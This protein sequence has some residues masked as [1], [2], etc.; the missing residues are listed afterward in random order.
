MTSGYKAPDVPAGSVTLELVR[1]ESPASFGSANREFVVSA[2]VRCGASFENPTKA[3]IVAA[4]EECKR[5]A[6]AAMGP[7]GAKLSG[8]TTRGWRSSSRG[9]PARPWRRGPAATA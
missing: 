8:S 6:E 4:V 2:F 7:R 1:D 3:G 5:N 9:S